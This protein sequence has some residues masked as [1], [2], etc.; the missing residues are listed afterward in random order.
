VSRKLASNGGVLASIKDAFVPMGWV[1]QV[2]W[3][4]DYSAVHPHAGC[5]C[6]QAN[7]MLCLWAHC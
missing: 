2:M 5:A 3:A 7:H 4:S 1:D 6:G